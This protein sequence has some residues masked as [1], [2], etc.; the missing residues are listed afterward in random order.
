MNYPS[1]KITIVAVAVLLSIGAVAQS[2]NWKVDPSHSSIGFSIDHMVISETVGEFNAYDM[3]VKSNKDDFTDAQFEVTIQTGS[4]DTKDEKRDGHLKSADFFDAEKY[5]TI[6]FK[7]KKLQ[8]VEGNKYKVT[9]LLTMHGITKE[10][11]L[12]A[13]FGGTVK[14]PW[15]GTR[16]GLKIWGEVDRYDYDLKYNSVLEAGG[17]AIGQEVRIECRIELV[18]G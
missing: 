9:G 17:L 1:K 6:T 3:I 4:I 2:T 5:P 11:T 8:K 12:D 10:V 16:A 18:K 13:K 14:D 15:G 7:G